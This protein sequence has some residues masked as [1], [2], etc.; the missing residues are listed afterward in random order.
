M[1][2]INDTQL[3][4]LDIQGK[5]SQIIYQSEALL[6]HSSS[7]V[8]GCKLLN[9]PIVW[10]EQT[11]DKL[12]ETHPLIKE[13]LAGLSPIAKT[14]FSAYGTEAFVKAIEANKRK[15]ILLIGIETHICIY[16]TA[17][18]LLS[19]GYQVFV[20]ADAVSSRAEENKNIG[21]EM[22]RQEQGKIT[23][24]EAA[25][26]ALLKSS[27]HEKFREIARLIK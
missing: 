4:I 9:L 23:N 14:T 5:L 16:Q 12:G 26:F 11:P 19:A 8:Q 22:I 18:D 21:L 24:V 27:T 13:H 1:L 20:V 25:L 2:S 7:L 17:I 6:K 15:Q 10:V 3:V